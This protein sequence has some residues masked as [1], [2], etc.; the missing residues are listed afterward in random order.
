MITVNWNPLFYVPCSA[1]DFITSSVNCCN[2]L[3]SKIMYRQKSKYP[4]TYLI[5]WSSYF[6]LSPLCIRVSISLCKEKVIFLLL[7]NVLCCRKIWCCY[8]NCLSRPWLYCGWDNSCS[9][10]MRWVTSKEEPRHSNIYDTGTWSR[11]S[12]HSSL[13]F[14]DGSHHLR[15]NLCVNCRIVP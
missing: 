3:L 13:H 4:Q 10:G 9:P 2:H 14:C 6:L 7:I 11:F 12:L 8:I 15:L 5:V 1:V